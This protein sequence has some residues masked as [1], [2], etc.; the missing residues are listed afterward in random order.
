MAIVDSGILNSSEEVQS[1][2]FKSELQYETYMCQVLFVQ[3]HYII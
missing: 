1:C 3:N 2:I